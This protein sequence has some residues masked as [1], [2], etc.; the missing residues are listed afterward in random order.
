M[1]QPEHPRDF[2]SWCLSWW[3]WAFNLDLSGENFENILK[4]VLNENPND[5]AAG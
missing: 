1:K 3:V 5:W 2:G 4:N